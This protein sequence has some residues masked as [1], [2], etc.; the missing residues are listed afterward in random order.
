MLQYKS[1]L[2]V[3]SLVWDDWNRKHI[4]K[5]EIT[6]EEVEEVCHGKYKTIKSYR[7][8]FMLL[9]KTKR[10][11]KLAVVLSPED[12]D[13]KIYGKGIYYLISSYEKEV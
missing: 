13:S 10:G 11:R 12:R 1:M 7:K 9:G 5:H 4:A 8:R 6:V 2:T 3:N